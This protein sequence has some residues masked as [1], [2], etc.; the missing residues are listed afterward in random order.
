MTYGHPVSKALGTLQ[1]KCV[2]RRRPGTSSRITV[3]S[4]QEPTRRH[5]VLTS[6]RLE[7]GRLSKT[8]WT[9]ILRRPNVS[10]SG[11]HDVTARRI[12]VKQVLLDTNTSRPSTEKHGDAMYPGAQ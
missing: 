11:E 3:P 9:T 10:T 7:V 6:G 12:G 4:R 8:P 5:D 2:A 1:W